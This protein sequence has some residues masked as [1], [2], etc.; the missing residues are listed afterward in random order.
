MK[1]ADARIGSPAASL[2]GG[3]QTKRGFRFRHLLLRPDLV[4]VGMARLAVARWQLSAIK[5]ADIEARN[6]R[7]RAEAACYRGNDVAIERIGIAIRSASWI[8]PWRSDCLVQAI[9]AQDWLVR[10]G[11]FSRI[12]IGVGPQ[13]TGS[14]EGHAWLL[15]GERIVTGGEV[16]EHSVLLGAEDKEQAQPAINQGG[17]KDL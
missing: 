10:H 1:R 8:V 12:V 17:F 5:S 2:P 15:A 9:A 3:A 4:I 6:Q 14:F 11:I 16:S 13:R 7:S